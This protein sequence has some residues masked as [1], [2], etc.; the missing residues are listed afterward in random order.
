MLNFFKKIFGK[1][2]PT[3]IYLYKELDEKTLFVLENKMHYKEDI[4]P[5]Y[6]VSFLKFLEKEDIDFKPTVA[7]INDFFNEEVANLDYNES[8]TTLSFN[9]IGGIRPIAIFCK[10]KRIMVG[11][12][13]V[14]QSRLDNS[15]YEVYNFKDK[16]RLS[17]NVIENIHF[18][19]DKTKVTIYEAKN[20][21]FST[22]LKGT[23]TPLP[24]D[25]FEDSSKLSS[26]FEL[27]DEL[28]YEDDERFYQSVENDDFV[29]EKG[30]VF[31]HDSDKVI[32]LNT[33]D[34]VLEL[35]NYNNESADEVLKLDT[36]HSGS[37]NDNIPNIDDI[38]NSIAGD[39]ES[40]DTY[41]DDN[42]GSVDDN[43]PNFD[44][45]SDTSY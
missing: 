43:V 37:V 35:D 23:K 29:L 12:F 24:L 18:G 28:N 38:Q 9:L 26:F 34:N 1:T 42:N 31:N 25:D 44:V 2:E 45:D 14:R 20:A 8:S 30:F 10:N 33:A 22:F 6:L 40:F 27:V 15:I 11:K 21:I 3:E 5:M 36:E 7:Q 17:F 13:T 4:S 19:E 41:T 32:D 16:Q 39:D